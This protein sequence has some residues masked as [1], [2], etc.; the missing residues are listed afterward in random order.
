VAK[1]AKLDITIK[2]HSK[3]ITI[4][5]WSSLAYFFFKFNP[6]TFAFALT[7]LILSN[8][9]KDRNEITMVME[10]ILFNKLIGKSR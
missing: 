8:T 3:I 2:N 7:Y 10:K 1:L 6:Q 4:D 5:D 9:R